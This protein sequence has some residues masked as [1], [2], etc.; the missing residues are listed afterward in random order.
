[1]EFNILPFLCEALS[2]NK[3]IYKSID[4]LYN[5]HRIE[6][7][8]VAKEN[9]FYNHPIAKQGSVIQDEYF[10]KSLGI[11]ICANEYKDEFMDILKKG[12]SYEYTTVN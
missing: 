10:R 2:I 4:K 9:E 6:F 11:G 8:K 3:K 5:K 12:W 7:Y 1:M